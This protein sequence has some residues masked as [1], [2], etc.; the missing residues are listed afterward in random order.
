MSTTTATDDRKPIPALPSLNWRHEIPKYRISRDTKP[1][2]KERFRFE[3]PF[4]SSSE[5][6]VWQYGERIHKAGEAIETTEWP[7]PGTM[8]PLNFSAQRVLEFFTSRQK[9][10]L[11]RSPWRD[12]QIHLDDGLS[13]PL[14]KITTPLIPRVAGV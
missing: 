5:S 14:P 9:S 4:S 10:R 7:N 3:P 6:D 13:N 11:Q 12:G 1:A 2:P 8:T